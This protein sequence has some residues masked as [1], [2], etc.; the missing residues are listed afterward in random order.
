MIPSQCRN[1]EVYGCCTTT[2]AECEAYH[3]GLNFSYEEK[4][5]DCMNCIQYCYC[6]GE[7]DC[8]YED[9]GIAKSS[10]NLASKAKISSREHQAVLTNRG[11]VNW[12]TGPIV[13]LVEGETMF[14][15]TI[16]VGS[17]LLTSMIPR[18]IFVSLNYKIGD[19]VTF[20]I[21]AL[22]VKILR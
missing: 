8:I 16:Q 17:Q 5:D 9:L 13:A 6:T 22:N 18:Q 21:K 20:A 1:C 12:L 14:M 11:L 15:V 2:E 10:E 19:Q 7:S 4:P 3:E